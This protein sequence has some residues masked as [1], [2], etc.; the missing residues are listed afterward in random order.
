MSYTADML[1]DV[2]LHGVPYDEPCDICDAEIEASEEG[3]PDFGDEEGVDYGDEDD[4]EEEEGAEEGNEGDDEEDDG[5][6][7]GEDDDD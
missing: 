4:N 5:P 2:C 6:N 1:D 7:D 3:D